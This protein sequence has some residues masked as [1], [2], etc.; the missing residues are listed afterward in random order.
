MLSSIYA[1]HF[2]WNI[3]EQRV[4]NMF[5]HWNKVYSCKLNT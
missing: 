2:V 5:Q 1:F 3:A 4:N